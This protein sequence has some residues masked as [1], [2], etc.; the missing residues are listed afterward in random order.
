MMPF[1]PQLLTAVRHTSDRGLPVVGAGC[2][3]RGPRPVSS[4]LS[5]TLG[6][7][8]EVT[9]PEAKKHSIKV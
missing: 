3:L 6:G 7:P 1:N 5:L 8:R 2:W 9:P 4:S